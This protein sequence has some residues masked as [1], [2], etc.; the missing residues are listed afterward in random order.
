MAIPEKIHVEIV[1][2]E[3][4]VVA[5]DVDE[6]V[7]PGAI[8]SFGVLPGHA[9]LLAALAPGLAAIKGSGRD[10]VFAISGG[11]ADVGPDHVTVLA[12]TCERAAEI[13]RERAQRK[14]ADL[15]SRLKDEI[16]AGDEELLRQKLQKQQARLNATDRAS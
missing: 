15:Q 13:D 12:E 2:P 4:R 9:P 6:V 7:L 5:R 3:R 14:L 16:P 11:F 10:E 8:G 1:T